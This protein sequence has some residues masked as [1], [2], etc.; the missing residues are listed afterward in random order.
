MHSRYSVLFGALLALARQLHRV[1][2]IARRVPATGLILFERMMRARAL[3]VTVLTTLAVICQIE[4]FIV[5][6]AP[7]VSLQ[8]SRSFKATQRCHVQLQAK[9]K[10]RKAQGKLIDALRDDSDDELAAQTAEEMDTKTY[11]K[12]KLAAEVSTPWRQVRLFIY[13][14]FALSAFIGGVTALSQLAASIGEQPGALPLTQCL[15]NIA[16]DFGV[17][18]TCVLGFN[19]ES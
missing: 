2:R 1:K 15:T 7:V 18:A 12:S 8:Q 3:P 4:A 9:K 16:I 13:S 14:G 5:P 6:A 11:D 10:G 19:F 17:V